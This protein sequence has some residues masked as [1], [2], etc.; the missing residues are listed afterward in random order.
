M[1]QAAHL[2]RS[3]V[4]DD[5]DMAYVEDHEAGA[6]RPA[7]AGASVPPFARHGRLDSRLRMELGDQICALFVVVGV[8]PATMRG[9][10]DNGRL[11]HMLRGMPLDMYNL[12]QYVVGAT[13]LVTRLRRAL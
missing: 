10:H 7:P 2:A 5:Q 4:N 12:M 11:V 1:L 6:D 9:I 3:E 8:R 13:T